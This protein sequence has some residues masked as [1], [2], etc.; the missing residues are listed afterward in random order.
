MATYLTRTTGNPT[1]GTKCTVSA[2]VKFNE[3]PGGSGTDRWL[4]GEYGNGSNHSYLYQRNSSQIG[5]YEADGSGTVASIITNR[6]CRD[7]NAWYHFMIVY[8]TT[9][10]TQAD[11]FKMYING[12]RQTSFAT[13]ENNISQNYLPRI[14]KTGRTYHIGGVSGVQ[15][16]FTGL[17][18]HYHHCDGSALAPTVFGSTD[19]TTGEWQINTSPSFTLG[20]NGF[21]ILK[22]GN[23]ITDQSTNS[24]DFALGAG[25]LNKTEDC[26]SNIFS[27]M[28][29]MVTN[30][31][32]GNFTHANLGTNTGAASW[33]S[34]FSSMGDNQGKYYCEMKYISGSNQM[35]GVYSL[36]Q[37]NRIKNVGYVGDGNL[38]TQAVGI[39]KPGNY[40]INGAAADY[41]G[42]SN[43][44]WTTGDIIMI[45]LDRDNNKVY[46]GKNGTW[47]GSGDP[48]SGSTG[49]GA[50][51]FSPIANSHWGFATSCYGSTSAANFGNG[52][53]QT[54]AVSSAGTN[55]SGNGIF[56]YNVPAGYTALSTKGLNS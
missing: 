35:F 24:N 22:D 51:S 19:S 2:W 8:D 47:M 40:Y 31:A 13:N 52:Y 33:R 25:T 4:F 6:L 21:T 29:P 5:W 32:N 54:T 15:T 18:S 48:T 45:A 16:M 26:P 30:N 41:T 43:T 49:T 50:I 23:T 3:L 1:L 46:F 9:D 42:G 36:D 17:M 27:I 34:M 55:A 38:G 14:N 44:S 28:N 53:F 12:E 20:S 10:S 11:R 37:K 56:E 7:V 39:A